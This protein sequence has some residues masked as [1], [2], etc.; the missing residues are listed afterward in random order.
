MNRRVSFALIISVMLCLGLSSCS[1]DEILGEI[2]GDFGAVSA[3]TGSLEESLHE[4]SRQSAETD[5]E[6]EPI[7][8]EEK[9]FL[10]ETSCEY[11]R[12]SLS[13][14]E[15]L[16]YDDMK[17]I[18]GSF[19][20]K[21]RLSEAGLNEGYDEAEIDRIFQYVLNDHPELFYVEGYSYTKYTKG[22][23]TTALE[24]TGTY[25][26]DRETAAERSEAIEAAVEE[27]LS[28][29]DENADQYTKVKYV[30]ER[31]IRDTEYDLSAPDNQN[32]Y[33]VFVNHRS[34]CQGYAK[35]VQYLLNRLGL[36]CTL[37]LGTVDT[38]EGHAWNLVKIDGNYYYLSSK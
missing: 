9:D 25:S 5:A 37:V 20:E 10:C 6:D 16:W 31:I 26:V 4:E 32:I 14:T 13:G 11:A 19:G 29:L 30:Y 3:E 8:S 21:V 1:G 18:L 7:A 34:V 33:S 15:Q 23:K 28:G 27:I 24:F 2:P 35:A 36:E 17:Q 38:G 12:K 22:D